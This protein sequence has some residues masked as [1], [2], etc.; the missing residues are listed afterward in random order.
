[1]G[2]HFI[3]DGYNLMK[4][5]PELAMFLRNGLEYAREAVL[6]RIDN[7]AG[8]RTA[9]SITVVF[10]GHI[11]GQPV[12]TRQRR[13]RMLVIYSKLGENADSVIKRLVA[14]YTQP[15]EVKVITRDWE[16]KDAAR[17][18]SQTSGVIK[19]RGSLNQT[20]QGIKE[21]PEESGWNNSTRKKGNSK[22]PPKKGRKKGPGDDV[23]W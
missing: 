17:Q 15:N 10:D 13:G 23:Y 3:I 12:E 19:R 11:N 1:M 2:L 9:A 8:L 20:R 16:L 5:D 14:E 7:A 18:A 6:T 4:T 21:E 22:R